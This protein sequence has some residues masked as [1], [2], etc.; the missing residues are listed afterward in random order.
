[1]PQNP[2]IPKQLPCLGMCW[3]WAKENGRIRTAITCQT[4]SHVP[5]SDSAL[6]YHGLMG[7]DFNKRCMIWT[8][9]TSVWLH[10]YYY[11]GTKPCSDQP[12]K[13]WKFISIELSLWRELWI[14]FIALP[15]WWMK[16][17]S[18]CSQKVRDQIWFSGIFHLH[19]FSHKDICETLWPPNFEHPTFG[20]C[21]TSFVEIGVLM[22]GLSIPNLLHVLLTST[23]ATKRVMNPPCKHL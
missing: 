23:C 12:W 14:P 6:P 10:I 1:M 22:E 9:V 4:K 8:D 16:C 20:A 11:S 13:Q 15:N 19:F 21:S 2:V 18:D 5:W 3:S 7:R 17:Q